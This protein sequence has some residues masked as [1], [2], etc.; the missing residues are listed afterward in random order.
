MSSV[1][2]MPCVT[3]KCVAADTHSMVTRRLSRAQIVVWVV[4]I[5]ELNGLERVSDLLQQLLH[6]HTVGTVCFCW[7]WA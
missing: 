1:I 6:A 7:T 5:V 2:D 3:L 4:T